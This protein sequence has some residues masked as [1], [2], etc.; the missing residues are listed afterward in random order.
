MSEKI[1]I[2]IVDDSPDTI[3]G[4]KKFISLESDIE[5]VGEAENGREAIIQAKKLQPDIVLMD[6][7]MPEMDGI[8]ATEIISQE[9]PDVGVIILS[10]QGEQEYLRKAMISGAN[11]YLV[12]P[13]SHDEL[14]NS[15]RKTKA[16][17]IKKKRSSLSLSEDTP[18]GE[19]I[20]IIGTKGGVGKSLIA[21]NLSVALKQIA[22]EKVAIMDLNLQFG[23][24]AIMLNISPTKTILDAASTKGD[25]DIEV[26]ETCLLIHPTGIKVLPAPSRPAEA[27]L[28]SGKLVK[29]ILYIL[30]KDGYKVIVDTAGYFT[31]CVLSA[32]DSSDLILLITT[33]DLPTIKN[34]KIALDTIRQLN[35][36]PDKIKIILNRSDSQTGLSY[37]HIEDTLKFKI[38]T[39]IPSDGKRVIPAVNSGVPFVYNNPEAE[40]S[41]AINNLAREIIGNHLPSKKEEQK[42]G[43][44]PIFK[45]FSKKNK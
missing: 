33:L 1:K 19:V 5:V 38:T 15:I 43:L 9:M 32:L 14:I 31:D 35:Y 7:N 13:F 29:N 40:I 37:Q 27:D 11:D 39:F 24:I 41:K 28:I 34:S 42:S 12:K 23:D 3:E 8:S 26:L 45:I 16:N 44:S 10:V 2:I 6:I 4:L 30:K 18:K 36:P 25:L 20:T 21:T 22:C 17:I